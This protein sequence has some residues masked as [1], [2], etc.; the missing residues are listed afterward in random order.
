M[1]GQPYSGV[2]SWIVVG[3]RA[4]KQDAFKLRFQIKEQMSS[5]KGFPSYE[6]GS[7]LVIQ[8]I[9]NCQIVFSKIQ[10]KFQVQDERLAWKAW[11]SS[12]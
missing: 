10:L 8:S 1:R 5:T 12:E 7:N 11:H 6:F 2:R 4:G 3:L 9:C